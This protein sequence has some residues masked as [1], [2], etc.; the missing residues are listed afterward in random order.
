MGVGLGLGFGLG[1]LGDVARVHLD[2]VA[3]GGGVVAL[4]L[5]GTRAEP[6]IRSG[7]PTIIVMPRREVIRPGRGPRGVRGGRRETR[8]RT[9]RA[10]A[11]ARDT[12]RGAQV[13]NQSA[14]C[15]HA[16]VRCVGAD[17]VALG[18]VSQQ[19]WGDLLVIKK[20]SARRYSLYRSLADSCSSTSVDRTIRPIS[21]AV[22]I[23]VTNAA[24]TASA[25]APSRN[26]NG[27]KP[28]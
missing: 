1:L 17:T 6:A 27:A 22:G 26:V 2:V 13:A 16:H 14:S 18:L 10:R 11:D 9:G 15:R 8:E 3:L 23:C 7:A 12:P 21:S 20:Q 24:A 4:C 5:R 25:N 28:G 19:L